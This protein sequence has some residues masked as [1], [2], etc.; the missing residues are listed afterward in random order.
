MGI[1][2]N[3]LLPPPGAT[4]W[5][6]TVAHSAL[7]NG[8]ADHLTRTPAGAGNRRTFTQRVLVKGCDLAASHAWF[9]AGFD[10]YTQY[11]MG[12]LSG[13]TG[14]RLSVFQWNGVGVLYNHVSD[15]FVV[16]PTAW[17]DIVAAVDTTQTVAADRVKLFVNG[18]Q[19]ATSSPVTGQ[20]SGPIPQ[21]YECRWNDV[22]GHTLADAV[23]VP[24]VYFADVHVV[25][26]QA[27]T[28]DAF[29]EWSD[30]VTGL[31]MPKEYTGTYGTNGFRLDFANAADLGAD[32]SGNGNHWTVGG[33]PVQTSDTPTNNHCVMNP[34]EVGPVASYTRC[35]LTNGNLTATTAGT[36]WSQ[37]VGTLTGQ[38]GAYYYEYT[39]DSAPANEHWL[40]F[41][42]GK[43]ANRVEL[44]QQSTGGKTYLRAWGS[45]GSVVEE[46]THVVPTAGDVI[47]IAVDT[48]AGT[49]SA[50]RNG[51]LIGSIGINGVPCTPV[52]FSFGV[53][54]CVG[55]FNFGATGFTYT[56]PSGHLSLC[57]ANLPDPDILR[58]STVADIVL[59]EGTGATAGVSSLEF[60]PDL[61]NIKDRD[62]AHQWMLFDSV[63]GATKYLN[64]NGTNAEGT[65]AETLKSFDSAGYTLGNATWVNQSGDSFLDLCLKAGPESGFEIVTYTG[66]GVAG[67]QI[68]HNLGKAPTFMMVKNLTTGGAPMSWVTYHAA[69]GATK[70]VFVD[71][72][73]AAVTGTAYWNDTEPTSTAFTLGNATNVNTNGDTYVAYLFTDS[74]IFKAFSYTG[75]ASTDGPFVNLGGRPLAVPFLKNTANG[76]P[77]WYNLDA[78]R[79]PFNP[80]AQYLQPSETTVEGTSQWA[81]FTSTGIKV[82]GSG[83]GYNESASLF[84]GLAILQ[85]ATK[86]ANAF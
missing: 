46:R 62:T 20:Y 11:F 37:S 52:F 82:I 59:R 64:T 70:A 45:F 55:T 69:L 39:Y 27:L 25:D 80:A 17:Y 10:A 18:R 57:A 36:S 66:N 1:I 28:P 40:G 72:T 6:Y 73:S 30:K 2:G 53:N 51:V 5:P 42:S 23:R 8:A 84:V 16:D 50:Y 56:P 14:V 68:A 13:A 75:N 3:L 38:D 49:F 63:R 76:S 78:V 35:G 58:S 61:V 67:R 4:V 21:N 12:N 26:G 22:I 71:L 48:V 15:D 86:Y 77:T 31:W 83:V 33:S 81:N 34:L 32:V 79:D 85:S 74:D 29:G 44:L 9:F 43:Y 65:N 24:S 54:A 19:V 7:F 60:T 41:Y 47:G